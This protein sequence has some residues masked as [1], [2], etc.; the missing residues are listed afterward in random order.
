[1]ANITH[2]NHTN[3][4]TQFWTLY[5]ADIMVRV[6]AQRAEEERALRANL[7]NVDHYTI[8]DLQ[9][10]IAFHEQNGRTRRANIARVMLAQR[11]AQVDDTMHKLVDLYTTWATG[12]DQELVDL[13][14]QNITKYTAVLLADK[15]KASKAEAI[16][17]LNL[18]ASY[19]A[20]HGYE[21]KVQVE[22]MRVI[23]KDPVRS[24]GQVV[25]HNH[26]SMRALHQAIRF[27][28]ERS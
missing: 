21:A 6:E 28:Q 23:V 19:L 5:A 26:V 12:D 7:S 2:T 18:A 20:R 14:L 27:V 9:G 10:V 16:D 13:A 11:L 24:N 8:E 15:E 1:M 22:A 25:S 4:A 3:I 17:G